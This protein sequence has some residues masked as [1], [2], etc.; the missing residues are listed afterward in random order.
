MDKFM[1]NYDL[2]SINKELKSQIRETVDKVM[3]EMY[4]EGK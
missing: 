3:N 1:E 4:E 2:D